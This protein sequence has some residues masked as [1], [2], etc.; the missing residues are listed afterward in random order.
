MHIMRIHCD[1]PIVDAQTTSAETDKLKGLLNNLSECIAKRDELQEKYDTD[2]KQMGVSSVL[3]SES[4]KKMDNIDN[5]APKPFDEIEQRLKTQIQN[6]NKYYK[7]SIQQM[8][9][10]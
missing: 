1:L 5:L 9:N 7:M 4:C 2:V 3:M 10:F 6:K 8:K